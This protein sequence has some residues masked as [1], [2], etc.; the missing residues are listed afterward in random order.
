LPVNTAT[1][2][3]DFFDQATRNA[4]LTEQL[5][6]KPGEAATRVNAVGAQCP[7][8]GLWTLARIRASVDWLA[9]YSLSGVWRVWQPL[10][11]GLRSAQVRRYSPDP[12]YQIKQKRLERALR[13]AAS[14]P[15]EVVVLFLD[16]FGY[17]RWLAGS[18]NWGSSVAEREG[19]NQQWRTIGALN[20]LTGQVTYLDNYIVGRRQVIAFYKRLVQVYASAR[21]IYLIQDN[22]NVHSHPNVL[23]ALATWPQLQL[24][25]WPPTRPG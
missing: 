19:H 1:G 6:Q 14:Q 17:Y 5:R 16:E 13:D 22:W 3:G 11:L 24:V 25:G 2:G 9:D 23:A 18:H 4:A 12:S 20:A 8:L 10:D 15:K 21:R 7:V